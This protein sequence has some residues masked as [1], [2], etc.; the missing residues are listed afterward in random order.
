L[1]EGELDLK[2]EGGA[3]DLANAEL[4]RPS[5]ANSKVAFPFV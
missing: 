3:R 4:D 2:A 5:E 1:A